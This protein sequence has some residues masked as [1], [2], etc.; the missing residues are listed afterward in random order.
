MIR[1]RFAVVLALATACL[2]G[3]AG[4]QELSLSG[5]WEVQKVAELGGPP[6]GGAWTP[7][8][9]P[10]YLR[11]SDYER[12]W[13]R[14]T[15]AVPKA[16]RGQRLKLRFGGVKYNSRVVVNGKRVGGCFGGYQPFEVD[17]T[18]A[19]DFDKPN[20]LLVGLH[21]WTGIF[22]PGKIDLGA[23][24]EWNRLRSR[25]RD[26]I[27]AP[28]GGLY[29]LYGIWDD[30]T[31]AAHPAVYVKDLFIKTSVRGKRLTVDYTL[32]NE[33]PADAQVDIAAAV[34]E[35]RRS[36]S[37]LRKSEN[38]SRP[39]D[40]D[41]RVVLRLPVA[42]VRVPAGGTAT[43]S[44]KAAWPNPHLW[45]HVD[46]HLYRL[47]TEL[48]SGDALATR[49]GFREFWVE[50]HRFV[51]NGVPINLLATSW[52]PPHAP[53]THEQVVERWR[54]IKEAGCVAFRTHTQPWRPV[55]YDVADEL[56]LL[57]IIEGAVWND[58]RVYRVEDGVFWENYAKHLKAMVDRDKNRPSVVMWSLENEM[59]GSRMNDQTPY[60]KS[61]LVRMGKLVAV[62]PHAAHLLRER[63]RPRRRGRRH[64]HPLPPRV[65]RLHLLAQR[66]LLARQA[67][68]GARRR[69][70]LPQRRAPLP[71]EEA[72]A[73]LRRRVPLAAV[74]QP[75]VAHGLL[76]RRRLHRLPPLPQPGQG[77]ELADADPRLPP[78]RGRRH[79]ALDRHRGRQARREQCPLSRPPVRLPAHR[80]LLPRP[81]PLLLRRRGGASPPRG[82]QRHPRG[83]NA[84]PQVDA[85][86]RRPDDRQGRAAPAP[87][88]DRAQAREGLPAHAEGRGAH[89]GRL[90][91]HGRARRDDRLR[92]DPSL[93]RLPAAA[94][95]CSE[96]EDRALR[97]EGSD[98]GALR[99]KGPAH[100]AR[101][102]ARP[103]AGGPRRAGHRR[104]RLRHRREAGAGHRPR[105][106]GACGARGLRRARRARAR[107][108][109][110][111]L[112]RG[113]LPH[114]PDEAEVHHDL[115]PAARPSRAEGRR[116][117][118]PEVL[119]RRP[120]GRGQ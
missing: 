111:G 43:V 48:S 105:G 106:A 81:R 2:A 78:L 4:R 77:R 50:G 55:H 80:R 96:G 64:R 71:L 19:V 12:A 62:G 97:P 31:L 108:R 16:M 44:A 37:D 34:E 67:V 5:R 92:R 13:F 47:R 79:L 86:A 89:A 17:V 90:A 38:R 63:R 42:R 99:G 54:A 82:L 24:K 120:H 28:I 22:T 49:F 117:R 18:D 41:A 39:R 46:P 69:R 29:G 53:M 112:S 10:G 61:Q 95:A 32:A 116:A 70:L 104:R 119:A 35:G 83:R 52:W 65:S 73:A 33:S 7:A 20:E 3:A 118:R 85:V 26:K 9:V 15:F 93:R 72:Q 87:D 45:S 91:R 107:A 110:A 66:G 103:P 56:G 1:C 60:A 11:G 21:D 36:F 25:P 27:L 14:R 58:D 6:K 98:A 114:R 8:A 76:R 23:T 94:P 84:Q 101:G 59:T 102:V 74:E 30:V 51:L 40:A 115:P 100:R 75:V 109:A 68:E 113:P 57:M 88:A